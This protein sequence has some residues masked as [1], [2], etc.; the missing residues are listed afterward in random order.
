MTKPPAYVIDGQSVIFPYGEK[1]VVGRVVTA[2]GNTARVCSE[3]LKVDT[4]FRVD[5]LRV[6]DEM[7]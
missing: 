5:D 3:R 7:A 4:W 1:W 2:M 6:P